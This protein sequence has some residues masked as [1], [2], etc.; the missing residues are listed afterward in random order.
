MRKFMLLLVVLIVPLLGTGCVIGNSYAFDYKPASMPDVGA[1]TTVVL[2]EP[3]DL[4]SYIVKGEEPKSFV[5]EMRNGYGMP[6]NV[7]TEGDRPFAEV[8]GEIVAR[9]LT[10]SGFNVVRGGAVQAAQIG[11]TLREKKAKR[12]LVITIRELGADTF[13]NIDVEWDLDAEVYDQNGKMIKKNNVKGKE[14]LE[15]S[16]MNPVKA[17]KKRVPEFIYQKVHELV[18]GVK[19]ALK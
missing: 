4:R 8:I 7:N 12:G 15:G 6:F 18:D 3:A 17:S 1:G 11:A 19:T 2:T 14:T 13:T 16:L 5:G 10:A 9:D